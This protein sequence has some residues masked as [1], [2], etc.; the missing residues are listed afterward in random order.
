MTRP[1][2]EVDRVFALQRVGMNVSQISRCM[3]IPRPTVR[4]WLF[5]RYQP[6]FPPR[7]GCFRCDATQLVDEKTYAYLLALYLGDGCLAAYPRNVWRLRIVQ[8]V[9]YSVLTLLCDEAMRKVSD[10]RVQHVGKI[11]CTEITCYWK[12]WI[13]VFPQHGEGPKWLRR[14]ELETWQQRIVDAEPRD[15]LAGLI[16]S[17]GCRFLNRVRRMRQGTLVRYYSYPRYMFT[18]NSDDIRRLFTDTCER[19][20][21]RW[22]QTNKFNVAVSRRNDVAFL[23]TFIGPKR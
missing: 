23:D 16:H 13:H 22:T 9:R 6:K 5:P 19:L 2:Y 17:D 8:D 20:D 12:H 15:F 4:E 7:A 11:G 10:R 21:L 1:R 14:I 18:N 3:G